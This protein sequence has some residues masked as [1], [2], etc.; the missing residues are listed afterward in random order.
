[1]GVAFGAE[2]TGV[3]IFDPD[4]P[5]YI[6]GAS[7][8][9]FLEAVSQGTNFDVINN[10]WGSTPIFAR[11]QNL[12][13]ARS[14]DRQTVDQYE[15]ISETGRDGLGTVVVQSAGNDHLNAN[16]DGINA[17]RFTITVAAARD[18]G[19][20]SSYSNYGASVLVTAPAGDR[21]EEGGRG[22]VT[23]D[24]LGREGYNLRLDPDGRHDYT[25]DFGGTSAAAPIVTGVV[26]LMLDANPELGWRDV[27]NILSLSATHTGSEIGGG[28]SGFET[29]PWLVNGAA[30]W[31][32]GGMH[33]SQ[34]YGY[35]MVDAYNAV[36][37]A[38]AWSLFA[39]AQTSANEE[40]VTTSVEVDQPIE[41][42]STPGVPV[43]RRRF[44]PDD[45]ARRADAHADAQRHPRPQRLPD[46]AGRHRDDAARTRP[47]GGRRRQ[48]TRSPGL[49]GSTGCAASSPRASGRCAS[50]TR[51]R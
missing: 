32:G 1:M 3:N 48:T 19:F 42:L 17:S 27:Q 40:S 16:G 24:L 20:T 46:L 12:A 23:T 35:G 6:N 8:A 10:S 43:H 26:A 31:N 22:I 30:N 13:V 50:R 4:S 36:R 37:M 25:D 14:F 11:S 5:I 9:G 29:S 47:P 21:A 51:W 39:P 2:L 15:Q 28:I 49:L 38:E 41:D 45:R 33:Y 34:D 18:D 7:S 44:R